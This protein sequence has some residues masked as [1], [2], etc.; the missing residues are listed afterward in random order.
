MRVH[1]YYIQKKSRRYTL[2]K[3][4]LTPAH[5]YLVHI[6]NIYYTLQNTPVKQILPTYPSFYIFNINIS[7]FFC[8]AWANNLPILHN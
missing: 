1:G 8:V 4:G 7:P 6:Q 3:A 2:Y 5:I